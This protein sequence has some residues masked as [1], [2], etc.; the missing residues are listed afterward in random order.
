MV[1]ESFKISFTSTG[2]NTSNGP[3]I[4]SSNA[5]ATPLSYHFGGWKWKQVGSF[6]STSVQFV[7]AK[8]IQALFE[9]W[10]T[11]SAR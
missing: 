11:R 10:I 2:S 5:L 9:R 1:N 7:H 4:G 8:T 3:L 6:K